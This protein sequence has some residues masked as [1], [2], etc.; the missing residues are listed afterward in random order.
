MPTISLVHN[1]FQ[2]VPKLTKNPRGLHPLLLLNFNKFHEAEFNL[3]FNETRVISN[4]FY[5][6][7]KLFF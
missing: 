5:F 2:F 7:E 1:F 6:L 4:S 3:E